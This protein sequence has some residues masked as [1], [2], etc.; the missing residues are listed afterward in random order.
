MTFLE[1]PESK[2]EMI[3]YNERVPGPKLANMLENGV[4]PLLPLNELEKMG[5]ALAAYPI[6]CLGGTIKVV[7]DVL[8]LIKEGQQSQQELMA[9]FEEVLNV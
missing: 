3:E 7:K 8:R 1:A 5:Y 4:T 9:S 6:S 2:E